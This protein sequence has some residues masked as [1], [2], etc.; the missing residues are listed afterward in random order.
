MSADRVFLFGA[1]GHA[2]VI[3]DILA[4]AGRGTVAFVIDDAEARRGTALFG[5]PVIG[6]REALIARRREVDA[7][8][9]SIGDNRARLAV[10]R[11]LAAEGFGFATAIH[12][13]AQV[14]REVRIGAGSVL[15]AGAIVNPD[16][17]IGDHCIVN[18]GA[19][20]DHDCRLGDAVHVAPGARLCGGVQ[21]GSG[22][23]VGAGAVIPPGRRVGVD[24]IIGAGAVVLAD[25][26][27][28]AVVAGNPAQPIRSP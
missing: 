8:I 4:R 17:G 10:A 13:S 3:A 2:K 27:D 11:W 12:P 21:V 20:V 15:M 9:V 23:F 19:S 7:G 26:P 16:A 6:G 24:A 14:A 18:T 22:A 25:V 1:S 5:H 28:R